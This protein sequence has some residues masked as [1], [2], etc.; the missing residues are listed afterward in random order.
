MT[1]T[2][3]RASR[4]RLPDGLCVYAVSDIHGC[5]EQLRAVFAAIDHHIRRTKPARAMHVFLG[6][7]IDRGPHPSQVID[8]LIE[9][10]ERHECVFLKGNHEQML[11]ELLRNA[12]KY[13]SWSQNGGLQTMLSYGLAPAIN[14]NVGEQKSLVETL[15]RKVPRLHRQ[16]FDALKPSFTIGD[17]FFV[18]AGAKPGIPLVEQQQKDMLWIRDEFLNCVTDFEKFIVHGHTP[19]SE[20]DFRPN[21]LNIDTGAY[22]TGKLTL[23]T[24]EGDRMFAI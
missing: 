15:A 7:Y 4:P 23:L 19:V 14:P 22:A 12:S 21:R 8:L 17:F 9:R 1:Q 24:I 13:E 20:P 2:W 16:F 6:D 5:A 3:S 10:G 18:H 11:F